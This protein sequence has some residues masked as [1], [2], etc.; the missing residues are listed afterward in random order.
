MSKQPVSSDLFY[1]EEVGYVCCFGDKESVTLTLAQEQ[2]QPD[3]DDPMDLRSSHVMEVHS[4]GTDIRLPV[5]SARELYHALGALLEE[6][7]D[8]EALK[9]E[10]QSMTKQE[11]TTPSYTELLD[12]KP[13]KT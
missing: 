10:V 12:K 11:R 7:N 9:R 1:D 2:W 6:D 4:Y 3:E 5:E 8:E 13:A